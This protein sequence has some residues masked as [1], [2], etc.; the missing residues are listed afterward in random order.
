MSGGEP[1]SIKQLSRCAAGKPVLSG[2][3][4]GAYELLF[5]FRVYGLILRAI[6]FDKDK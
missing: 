6:S 1:S 2:K 5:E 4:A 3:R